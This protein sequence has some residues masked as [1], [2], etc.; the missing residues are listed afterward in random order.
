MTDI[1][2]SAF[3]VMYNLWQLPWSCAVCDRIQE[4]VLGFELCL[5]TGCNLVCRS[6]GEFYT[7]ALVGMLNR[8][9]RAARRQAIV[10]RRSYKLTLAA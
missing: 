3:S 2:L 5:V 10:A 1:K 6:C 4:P 8:W 7:P 9:E